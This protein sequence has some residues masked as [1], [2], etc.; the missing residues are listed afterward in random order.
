MMYPDTTGSNSY[1]REKI[2]F[3]KPIGYQANLDVTTTTGL[4][5]TSIMAKGQSDNIYVNKTDGNTFIKN[6]DLNLNAVL[7]NQLSLKRNNITNELLIS[8]NGLS[9]NN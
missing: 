7:N 8:T 4:A 9:T 6:G 1:I 3:T 5:D 2:Q